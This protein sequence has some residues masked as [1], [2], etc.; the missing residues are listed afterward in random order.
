MARPCSRAGPSRAGPAAR[1]VACVGVVGEQ[2]LVALELFEA[3]IARMRAFE[4]GD[5]LLAWLQAITDLA[6]RGLAGAAPAIDERAGITRVVQRL[7]HA[8]VRQCRPRQLAF[9]RAGAHARGEQQL[10]VVERLH[11]GAR[12]AGPLERLEKVAQ[13]LLHGAVGIEHN[14]A[15]RVIDQADRQ[16]QGQLAA[17]RLGED[18]A[19]QPRTDEVQLG[20]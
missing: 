13:R 12:R 3:Q 4:Q 7:Q 15:R 2:P 6:V 19:L 9:A 14:V 20:L 18:A 16:R 5:P 8:P 11:D 1:S 17:A 10:L